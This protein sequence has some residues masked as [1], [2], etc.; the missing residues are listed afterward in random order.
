MRCG[1]SK[2]ELMSAYYPGELETIL[3][4]AGEKQDEPEE[5]YCAD[6]MTFLN[7]PR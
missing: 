3:A 6:V 2:S 1:V 7:P 4:I 5:A